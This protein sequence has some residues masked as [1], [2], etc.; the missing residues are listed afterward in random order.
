MHKLDVELDEDNHDAYRHTRKKV[1]E[2][3]TD[4]AYVEGSELSGSYR[5]KRMLELVV[6]N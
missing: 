5:E 6:N 2:S 1:S 4:S 3:I